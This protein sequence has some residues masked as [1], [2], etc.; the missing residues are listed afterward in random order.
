MPKLHLRHKEPSAIVARLKDPTF[1]L[2]CVAVLAALYVLGIRE[3]WTTVSCH[4][5]SQKEAK[6]V[7]QKRAVQNPE[8]P[9]FRSAADAALYANEDYNPIFKKCMVSHGFHITP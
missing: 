4:A 3:Q 8:N 9:Q 2:T 7:M 1:L 6:I 5:A